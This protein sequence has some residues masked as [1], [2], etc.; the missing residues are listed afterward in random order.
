MY[1]NTLEA[2]RSKV[3]HR[4]DIRPAGAG[5]CRSPEM[6]SMSQEVDGQRP[7]EVG[8]CKMDVDAVKLPVVSSRPPEVGKRKYK[9]K[10]A[11]M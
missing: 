8:R 9:L 5:Y 11:S 4:K 1:E 2:G 3:S 7:P 10:M 6:G